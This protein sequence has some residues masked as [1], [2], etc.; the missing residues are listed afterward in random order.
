MG[1]VNEPAADATSSLNA[2]DQLSL[3]IG[4]VSRQDVHLEQRLRSLFVI[5]ALPGLGMFIPP[6][7]LN[8]LA[9]SCARMLPYARLSPE[10][11]RAAVGAVRAAKAAHARRNRVVHD[12]WLHEV[13]TDPT[14]WTRWSYDRYELAGT[15]TPQ[16]LAD[17]QGTLVALQRAAIRIA[18]L[19]DSM[20]RFEPKLRASDEAEPTDR[21]RGVVEDRFD[22]G[23]NGVIGPPKG[24]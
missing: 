1:A 16:T 11:E 17:V 5:L 14:K 12:Q 18:V 22:I 15:A 21:E 9:D 13:G 23:P 24:D 4:R 7:D 6:Q 2:D 3:L 8:A 19:M 10:W 20:R